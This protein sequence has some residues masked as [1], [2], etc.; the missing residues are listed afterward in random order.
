MKVDNT[1]CVASH[2]HSTNLEQSDKEMIGSD[3][4]DPQYCTPR[5]DIQGSNEPGTSR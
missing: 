5:V 3:V 4:V 1:E 2:I